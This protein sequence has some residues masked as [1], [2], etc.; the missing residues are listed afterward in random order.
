MKKPKKALAIAFVVAWIIA[1]VVI[2]VVVYRVSQKPLIGAV[3]FLSVIFGFALT[4]LLFAILGR[5][6]QYIRMAETM[7]RAI[8][9]MPTLNDPTPDDQDLG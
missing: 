6:I 8:Q 4:I 3:I 5:I 9:G 7:M 1:T 2:G